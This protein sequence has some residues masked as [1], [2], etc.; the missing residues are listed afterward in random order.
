VRWKL[1]LEYDGTNFCGWQRQDNGLSVQQALE[2]AIEKFSGEKVT[3]TAAGR[4][5]AGVHAKGQVA[6][7]DIAKEA[8]ADTVRDAINAHLRPHRIAVLNAESVNEDFHARFNAQSRS[9]RYQI[10]NRRAPPALLADTVWHLPKPLEI[11]PMQEAARILIGNHD[12]TTFRARDCQAK[13]P[14]KTLDALNIT[15]EDEMI[16]V[17]ARA[18]SFL[19]HQVRNMVGTLALVGSGQ[20]NLDD[21]KAAFAARDRKAGGPTAPAQGLIFWEVKY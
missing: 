7:G 16:I 13:S 10:L 18:R 17:E 9:Y 1:T 19:Y 15:R 21:F 20:W 5:D 11:A 14:V 12:F 2:E 6:H 8:S 4:T 3:L